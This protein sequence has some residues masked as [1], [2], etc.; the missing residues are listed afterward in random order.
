MLISRQSSTDLASCSWSFNPSVN[1][2]YDYN[3]LLNLPLLNLLRF[4]L[5]HYPVTNSFLHFGVGDQDTIHPFNGSFTFHSQLGTTC[6]W[7]A[8][9]GVDDVMSTRLRVVMKS[10]KYSHM[11]FCPK[12]SFGGRHEQDKHIQIHFISICVGGGGVW[13]SVVF[14]LVSWLSAN[15]NK[16]YRNSLLPYVVVLSKYIFCFSNLLSKRLPVRKPI[17]WIS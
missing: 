9:L 16:F 10:I 3:F 7:V 2:L 15:R 11:R 6:S 1:C 8:S 17:H 12:S 13:R 14:M 4:P 5:N